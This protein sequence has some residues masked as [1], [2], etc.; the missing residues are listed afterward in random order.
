MKLKPV[1][2]AAGS[3]QPGRLPANMLLKVLQQNTIISTYLIRMLQEN[4]ADASNKKMG[5][6]TPGIAASAL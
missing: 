5:T 2:M 1:P 3:S 4:Y 6:K